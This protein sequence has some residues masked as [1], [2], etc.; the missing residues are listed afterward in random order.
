MARLERLGESLRGHAFTVFA[1]VVFPLLVLPGLLPA[2]VR[3]PALS[4]IALMALTVAAVQYVRIVT[5]GRLS[6]IVL[7]FAAF[8][9]WLV[10]P[11]T[12]VGGASHFGGF[13]AGLVGMTVLV[14]EV[15]TTARLRVAAACVMVAALVVLVVGI[16]GMAPP[17][18]KF[19]LGT[20][21]FGTGSDA[22]REFSAT[23]L[24]RL[25]MG[26]LGVQGGEV[27]PNALGGTALMLG[28]LAAGILVGGRRH[29]AVALSILALAV[30]MLCLAAIVLSMSRT[31]LYGGL[32]LAALAVCWWWRLHRSG[33]AWALAGAFAA[34]GALLAGYV[35]DAGLVGDAGTQLSASFGAR[36]VIWGP[37]VSAIIANPV[38]GV[39]FNNMAALDFS[40]VPAI[41]ELPAHAHNQFLQVALDTGLVGLCAYVSFLAVIVWRGGTVT[42]P[43]VWS[44]VAAGAAF[45]ILGIHAFGLTDTIALG[46]KVGLF[47]WLAAGLVIALSQL[48]RGESA[49]DTTALTVCLWDAADAA[50]PDA[51]VRVLWKS[52]GRGTPDEVSI[53]QLVEADADALRRRY[54]EWVAALCD[55]VVDGRPI[56]DWFRTAE[57]S[58]WWSSLLVEKCNFEKSPLIEDAIRVFAFDTWASTRRIARLDVVTTNEPLAECLRQWCVA[59]GATYRRR[60]S[61]PATRVHGDVLLKDRIVAGLPQRLQALSWLILYV[62]RRWPLRGVGRSGWEASAA[63]HTFVSYLVSGPALGSTSGRFVGG[64]WGTL[65]P[66]LEERGVATNWL[67]LFMASPGLPT[68]TEAARAIDGFN[69]AAG[70]REHHTS[71]DAFLSLRVVGRALLRWARIASQAGRLSRRFKF[72]RVASEGVAVWPLFA[73]DYQR[74]FYGS[75]GLSNLLYL[76]LFVA[77]LAPIRQQRLGVYLQEHIGWEASFLQAWRKAGHGQTVGHP[78]STIRFWDLRYFW[79]P[80]SGAMSRRPTPDRT[81]INGPDARE[82]LLSSGV[83]SSSLVEVEALRYLHLGSGGG[84]TP[85]SADPARRRLL[86]LGDFSQLHSARLLTV[87]QASLQTLSTHW[88]VVVKPHPLCPLDTVFRDLPVTFSAEPLARLLEECDVVLSGALTA[89]SLE[90]YCLGR[91]VVVLMSPSVLNMS[92]LR[93]RAGVQFVTADWELTQALDQWRLAGDALPTPDS[94]FCVDPSLRRWMTMLDPGRASRCPDTVRPRLSL[95]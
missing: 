75:A 25:P 51:D 85:P 14:V 63:E 74:S 2:G 80:Q 61:P 16:L 11:V 13:V 59:A 7:M 53:P 67:H 65:A 71:L 47:Q 94:I 88:T 87:L 55:V 91:P 41:T 73:D 1:A 31:A 40:A 39:G 6:L 79:A 90:A 34:G 15:T 86:V 60:P 22:I 82:A 24:P 69:R 42:A 18:S 5:V 37:A 43:G 76:E 29:R 38:T 54:L 83:A 8:A 89:A 4:V 48:P 64:F 12:S 84:G 93:G 9:G 28:P 20:D 46:A 58:V 66:Q 44:S 27:N 50:P 78:H 36:M 33:W 77:A 57:G 35:V 26:W 3:A 30:L 56:D 68:A 72:E 49:A 19:V 70:G 21:I 95:T 10:T 32:L 62:L 45:S 92:P 52:F 23:V 17:P 81:A